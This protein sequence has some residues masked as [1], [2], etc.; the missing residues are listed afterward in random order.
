MTYDELYGYITKYVA[1][2]HTTITENDHRRTCLILSAFMEFILD[3]QD[4]GVDANTIDITDFIH[5]KLD[6]LEGKK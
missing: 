1:S 3:C 4:E 6:I 5:E 2:P